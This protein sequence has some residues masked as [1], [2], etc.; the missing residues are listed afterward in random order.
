MT[1]RKQELKSENNRQNLLDER[2]R[3][4]TL[5]QV[6]SVRGLFMVAQKSSPKI[7]YFRSRN[8]LRFL[9]FFLPVHGCHVLTLIDQCTFIFTVSSRTRIIQ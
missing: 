4:I 6:G 1:I 2:V 7:V 9:Y 5:R 8:N 3:M